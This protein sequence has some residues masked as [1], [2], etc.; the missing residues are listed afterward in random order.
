MLGMRT[1]FNNLHT[2]ART[3]THTVKMKSTVV[4]R[5][6]VFLYAPTVISDIVKYF[7]KFEFYMSGD[8]TMAMQNSLQYFRHTVLKRK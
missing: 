8:Q 5:G 7:R 1:L 4:E 3:H 2:Q 6:S